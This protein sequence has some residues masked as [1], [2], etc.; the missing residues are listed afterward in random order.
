[1]TSEV[2]KK[3]QEALDKDG[4]LPICIKTEF[5]Y[6]SQVFVSGTNFYWDGGYA[7]PDEADPS[8]WISSL[9]D[10]QKELREGFY[11]SCHTLEA[12]GPSSYEDASYNGRRIREINPESSAWLDKK[13]LEERNMFGGELIKYE[14]SKERSEELGCYPFIACLKSNGLSAIG[15][16]EGHMSGAKEALKIKYDALKMLQAGEADP[17]V[18]LTSNLRSEREIAKDFLDGKY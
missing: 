2:I 10:D 6:I 1:M 12:D 3:L 8:N 18:L 11:E 13:E 14:N 5:G 16:K 17:A 15:D 9:T 4:D 7:A